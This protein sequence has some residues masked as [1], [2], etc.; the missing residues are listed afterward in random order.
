MT[1]VQRQQRILDLY[2]LRRR[3]NAEIA[4]HEK[5]IQREQEAMRRARA[6]AATGIP[7]PT[8]EMREGHAAFNRGER[9]PEVEALE[10]EYQAL[11]KRR[12]RALRKEA[13]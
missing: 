5:A 9:T 13:A 7:T 2:D 11:I 1:I 4:D 8:D 3:I 6:S 12:R 10:R